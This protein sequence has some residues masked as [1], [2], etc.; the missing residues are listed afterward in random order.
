MMQLSKLDVF[1]ILFSVLVQLIIRNFS[2][3][4]LGHLP[5]LLVVKADTLKLLFS[6]AL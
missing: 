1:H 6:A 2:L 3:K 5:M 4:L